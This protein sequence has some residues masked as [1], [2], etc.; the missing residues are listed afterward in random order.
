MVDMMGS[1][2]MQAFDAL[3]S[4]VKGLLLFRRGNLNETDV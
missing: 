3:T 2:T 4:L 1:N